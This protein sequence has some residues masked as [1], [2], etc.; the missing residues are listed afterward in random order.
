MPIAPKKICAHPGCG[1]TVQGGRCPVHK[2]VGTVESERPTTAKRGYDGEWQR[3]R[4]WFVARHPTCVDCGALAV[5]VHHVVPIGEQ[6]SLKLSEANCVA[7]CK[8][9]HTK[10]EKRC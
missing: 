2:G 8:S 5:D 3:F 4:R 7:L 9:C 1:V 10:R 6:P